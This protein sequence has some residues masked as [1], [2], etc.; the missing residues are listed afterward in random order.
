M[1]VT[2]SFLS[3]CRTAVNLLPELTTFRAAL[4][5]VGAGSSA[6]RRAA[7]AACFDD[8]RSTDKS[9]AYRLRKA[10]RDTVRAEADAAGTLSPLDRES[11]YRT[12]SAEFVPDVAKPHEQARESEELQRLLIESM[13]S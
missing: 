7:W 8:N 2:D 4:A 6:E 12:I 11:A 10:I 9:P 13:L 3:T 5:T 1:P